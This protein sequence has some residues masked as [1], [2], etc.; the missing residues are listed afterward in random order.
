MV[1]SI[2]EFY[3]LVAWQDLT[4]VPVYLFFNEDGAGVQHVP[5]SQNQLLMQENG[6]ETKESAKCVIYTRW[7]RGRY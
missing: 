5:Q 4:C 6:Q 2:P 3:I 7:H 1:I